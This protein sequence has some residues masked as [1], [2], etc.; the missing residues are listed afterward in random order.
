MKRM[1]KWVEHKGVLLVNA[2]LAAFILFRLSATVL[3]SRF[4][5]IIL[6]YLNIFLIVQGFMQ[7]S[8]KIPRKRKRDS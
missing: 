2:V 1:K 6:A 4:D 5:Y 7:W 8:D 3:L